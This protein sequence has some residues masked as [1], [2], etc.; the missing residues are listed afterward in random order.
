MMAVRIAQCVCDGKHESKG[1]WNAHNGVIRMDSSIKSGKGASSH[2]IWK[3]L[4]EVN[5]DRVTAGLSQCSQVCVSAQ[6]EKV[7]KAPGFNLKVDHFHLQYGVV[8]KHGE[9]MSH[10]VDVCVESQQSH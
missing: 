7:A 1:I 6:Y 3:N 10:G 9:E 8:T 5:E 2:K 4:D